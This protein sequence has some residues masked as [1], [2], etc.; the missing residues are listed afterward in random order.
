MDNHYSCLN[1]FLFILIGLLCIGT[2]GYAYGALSD[3]L[4]AHWPFS[5]NANDVSGKGNHGVVHGATMAADRHGQ[6]NSAH[7]GTHA[8]SLGVHYTQSL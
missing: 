3:G 6:A 7:G 4:V 5:G 1:V 2:S 8:Y